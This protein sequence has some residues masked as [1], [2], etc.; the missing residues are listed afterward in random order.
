MPVSLHTHSW[1]SLLEG[2]SSPEVLVRHALAGGYSALALTDTNNLYGAVAF[3]ES[4]ARAG[5]R[6]IVG[7]QLRHGG[8]RAVALAADRAG[9]RSLC[10]LIS[11]IHMQD[12]DEPS[13][14]RIPHPDF[15]IVEVLCTHNEGLHLLVDEPELAE[16]LHGAFRGRLWLEVVRP[17]RPGHE[18]K[19]RACASRL[20]LRPVAST[21]AHLVCPGE[22][23]ALRAVTA[24]RENTLLDRV[25][26]LLDVRPEHRLVPADELRRRFRDLP[27]AVRAGDDLADLLRSDVLPRDLILPKPKLTRPLDLVRYLRAHCERGL[28]D[29]G[30]GHDLAARRRLHEEL[31]IIEANGLPGYFL[32]VRDITREVRRRGHT[33]ALRGSAGNS[34]VCY[35][36]GI[37]EV[38]PLRFGLEMERFLHP[39]RADLPD[40]DLDFDWKVRDEIIEYVIGRYGA[41]HVARISAHQFLQPRSAFREAAKIHGL[42]DEQVSELLTGLEE[43]VDEILLPARSAS[44]VAEKSPSLALRAGAFPLEPPRWPRLVADARR[45]LGRPSH[46]SLH[47]GGIVITPQ[48][49]D[50][51]ASVQ[52]AAKGVVMTQFEKDAVERIGLVKIDL[53]GNRALATVDEARRHARAVVPAS[54]ACDGDPATADLVRRGDT[55]GVTQLESPAMRHLLIQMRA[56]GLDDVIQALALLRPGAASIGMKER[57]IRRR[58][59]LEPARVAHPALQRV[60]GDTEGL[61]LYEDDALRL[62]Q[63]LAGLS[64]ADADRFR[65]RVSK[66]KTQEEAEALR[67]EFVRLCERRGVPAAALAELWPQL[68]KFNRYSFCKSHAVSYGLIAWQASYLKAHHPLAFWTAALNNNMG[69]YPRRVYVEA[70]KRAGVELRL[71]CANR[72]RLA[73]HPEDGAIRVGLDAIAGLPDELKASLVEERQRDGPYEG[74]GD[75]RRR[76]AVGPEALATLIRAGAL[77]FTGRNRPALFLEARLREAWRRQERSEELFVADPTE[78]WAPPDDPPERRW[79]DEWE[80]LGFVLG[81]PLFALFKRPLPA[82]GAPLVASHEVPA[83]TGRL[84]RVQGLVATMRHT[85][86]ADDRP[87]QFVTLEDEHGFVEVTLFSGTCARVPPYLTMGPYVATGVVEE[88]QGAYGVTARAFERAEER[89]PERE[90]RVPSTAAHAPGSDES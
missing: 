78:G 4:A 74:L 19:L 21:A 54:T 18:E 83:R 72:S 8:R 48:P 49:I 41:A 52:W 5:L 27:E 70:V 79:H 76:V 43:R 46:L 16:R 17:G 38:D 60:L 32:A 9:Y 15:C 2:V 85:Y 12:A 64:A 62:I 28:R 80:T 82:R 40:I 45:L 14:F 35:L 61:M 26:P 7:A 51:Y 31:T 87:I 10:R 63:A 44:D 86:S 57:F 11:R 13:P 29:R 69:A 66:H 37:T 6:P 89:S 30:L 75:L 33:M 25:P 67:A 50:S 42:S 77:D 59:G 53:L 24:V 58:A 84:V 23:P 3:V 71:P 47:P 55:L 68:A 73:F 81:P 34:L 1:Y 20:R 90:R 39:G 56:G 88:R 65:K 22:Y 36:L